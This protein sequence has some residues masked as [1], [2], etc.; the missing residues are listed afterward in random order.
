MYMGLDAKVWGT[1]TNKLKRLCGDTFM[2]SNPNSRQMSSREKGKNEWNLILVAVHQR[3]QVHM[4]LLVERTRA[5]GKSELERRCGGT[6]T[7][8]WIRFKNNKIVV[9]PRRLFCQLVH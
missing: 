4:R 3:P 8:T 2:N 5:E 6:Q 1:S 9:M 7:D